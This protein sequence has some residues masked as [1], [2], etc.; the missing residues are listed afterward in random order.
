MNRDPIVEETRKLR[1]D[2]ASRHG[3][4]PDAI[5]ADIHRRESQAAQR[6]VIC[7]PRPARFRPS[8]AKVHARG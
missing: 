6:T 2:Y 5:F 4:D 8:P 7:P 3:N 1:L